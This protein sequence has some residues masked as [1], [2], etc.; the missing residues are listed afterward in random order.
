MFF[1]RSFLF[2]SLLSVFSALVLGWAAYIKEPG[3]YRSG[4]AVLETDEA[5]NDEEVLSLLASGNGKYWHSSISESS[6]W[7]MLDEFDSLKAVPLNSYSERLYSFDPRNDGYAGKLLNFFVRD[8]KRYIYLRLGEG[9]HIPQVLEKKIAGLLEDKTFSVWFYGIGKPL[10]FFFA[11]FALSALSLLIICIIKKN[12]LWKI[13]KI[14]L[15]LPVFSSLAFFGAPG[16]AAAALLLGLFTVFL[17]LVHEL[18]IANK[19]Q[20]KENKAVLFL[21]ELFKSF[22]LYLLVLPLFAAALVTV[23]M[24]TEINLIYALAVLSFLFV[25]TLLSNRFL[26]EESH[27][28]FTPVLII[29]R[30]FPD[31]AFSVYMIPFTAAAFLAMLFTP[32][33][34]GALI[35]NAPVAQTISEQEYYDHLEFQ[36]SFSTRQLSNLEFHYH[37]YILDEDGLPSPN[38]GYIKNNSAGYEFPEFPL[39]HLMDFM[40]SVNTGNRMIPGTENRGIVSNLSL[41]LLLLFIIPVFLPKEKNQFAPKRKD[42]IFS[43]NFRWKN[44]KRKNTHSAPQRMRKDA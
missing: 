2:L 23:V 32:S 7:V 30:R 31:F 6:Q 8:G 43:V 10:R 27:R 34:S 44:I 19:T 15:L 4:Y 39:K 12:K 41:L 1:F 14:I 40:E 9:N 18:K 5:I 11:L 29:R 33:M 16:I 24:V 13:K 21:R 37:D 22:R 28:R 26:P 3:E 25:I 42:K 20:S 17:E 38:A 35:T 36:M